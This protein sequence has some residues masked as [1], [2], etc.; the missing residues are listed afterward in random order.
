ME[1]GIKGNPSVESVIFNAATIYDGRFK[2]RLST[3]CGF[4]APLDF[5]LT[6]RYA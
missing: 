3:G 1:C 5:A 6:L 2:E 4:P